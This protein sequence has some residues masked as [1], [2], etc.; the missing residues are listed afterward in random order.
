MRLTGMGMPSEPLDAAQREALK[1]AASRSAS[2]SYGQIRKKLN[3]DDD[4]FFHGLYYGEKTKE[5]AEKR[6]WPQ[7]Q[8]YH[9]MRTALDKVGKGAIGTLTE[10]QLNAVATILT[11]CKSDAKRIAA[12]REA[13]YSTAV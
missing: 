11:E 4:V 7:M 1:S 2:L 5:E 12:L 3:L 10:E 8:S 6:K 13:R 9:K